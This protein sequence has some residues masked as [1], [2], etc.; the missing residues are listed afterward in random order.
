[1][2]I[3]AITLTEGGVLL[4]ADC[5]RVMCLCVLQYSVRNEG[6]CDAGG[7]SMKKPLPKAMWRLRETALHTN[8]PQCKTCAANILNISEAMKARMARSMYEQRKAVQTRHIA[9]IL[10]E[11]AAHDAVKLESVRGARTC[12]SLDDASGGYWQFL[13]M[14]PNMRSSKATASKWKY[15]QHL[16]GNS[17]AGIG[18]YLS[19]L[20]P[21]LQKGGNF[22]LTSYATTLY[23]NIKSGALTLDRDQTLRW[24]GC[25]RA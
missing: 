12:F 21:M 14:P 5:F 13:P 1:M 7:G 24:S 25:T 2:Y 11:R 15:R 20:P 16:Q 3:M 10:E 23:F 19:F 8:F 6:I 9:D 17:W 18:N 22:G 4:V